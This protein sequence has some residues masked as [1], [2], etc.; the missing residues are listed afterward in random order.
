LESFGQKTNKSR[1]VRGQ[2]QSISR[3]KVSALSI[4][5][6]PAAMRGWSDAM[7]MVRPTKPDILSMDRGT[8]LHAKQK[9]DA[10]AKHM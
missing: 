2:A 9:G 10:R 7:Q 1:G 8:N 3:A 5:D 4:A 6:C